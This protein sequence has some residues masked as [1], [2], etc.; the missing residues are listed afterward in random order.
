MFMEYPASVLNQRFF[1][2][3]LSYTNSSTALHSVKYYWSQNEELVCSQCG[4]S[5]SN[6]VSDHKS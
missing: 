5:S 2:S 1:M 4:P 3:F 6:V